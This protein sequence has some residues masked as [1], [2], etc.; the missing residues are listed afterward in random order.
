MPQIPTYHA[1]IPAQATK[2]PKQNLKLPGAPKQFQPKLMPDPVAKPVFNNNK[3]ALFE[4]GAETFMQVSGTILE[5]QQQKNKER[6]SAWVSQALSQLATDYQGYEFGTQDEPGAYSRKGLSADGMTSEYSPLLDD[7]IR[8][9]VQDAPDGESAEVFQIKANSLRTS[10]IRGIARHQSQQM[11]NAELEGHAN[12][13]AVQQNRI[14]KHSNWTIDQI[15][16]E[17]DTNVLPEKLAEAKMRGV[18][19]STLIEPAKAEMYAG[20]IGENI[21]AGKTGKAEGMLKAKDSIFSTDEVANMKAS[22]KTKNQE[23]NA[24]AMAANYSSKVIVGEMTHGQALE[25]MREEEKDTS[26]LAIQE[27]AAI[28]KT[29]EIRQKEITYDAAIGGFAQMDDIRFKGGTDWLLKEQLYYNNFDGPPAVKALL[30]KK[31][32]IDK[33]NEGMDPYTNAYAYATANRL[34]LGMG[35][36]EKEKLLNNPKELQATYGPYVVKKDMDRL[37]ATMK[38]VQTAPD[39]LTRLAWTQYHGIRGGLLA[40]MDDDQEDDYGEFLLWA[41]DALAEENLAQDPHAIRRLVETYMIDGEVPGRV[42]KSPFDI[43]MSFGEALE[44][45]DPKI[46]RAWLPNEPTGPLRKRLDA[47]V[48]RDHQLQGDIFKLY[49]DTSSYFS[50]D[51]PTLAMDNL[52]LSG[53]EREIAVRALMKGTL[54]RYSKMRGPAMG[55]EEE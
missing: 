41:G 53:S 15:D 35:L 36:Q 11:F 31:L 45:R 48:A 12:N 21:K 23:I 5:A 26:K 49:G 4:Q 8:D 16:A 52:G 28:V 51:D 34:I 39:K 1:R 42:R 13:A 24:S 43:D 32:D 19:P 20:I 17:F 30:K 27:Y 9:I 14:Q 44:T 37:L 22:I 50:L 25:K 2:L 10:T 55:L 18:N 40:K 38:N 33:K 7:S 3:A 46:I 29:N 54:K 47:E 6:N